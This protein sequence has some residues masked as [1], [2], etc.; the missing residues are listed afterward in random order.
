[1]NKQSL[2]LYTSKLP[3]SVQKA[4]LD[5]TGGECYLVRRRKRGK[6]SE[7]ARGACHP[8]VQGWVDKVGGS[9]VAGWLLVRNNSLIYNGLWHWTFHSVWKTPEGEL[10]DVTRD[11][12]YDGK[13]FSTFWFDSSRD[14][15]FEE[16]TS[17]NDIV[18]FENSILATAYSEKYGVNATPGLVYWAHPSLTSIKDIAEHSGIYRW[19][20]SHY[21]KNLEMMD[22]D[23]AANSPTVYFDYDLSL[24]S[25]AD[26][27]F[28]DQR[29]WEGSLS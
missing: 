20:F 23:L 18:I 1:M 14:V 21:P 6:T 11:P 17:Y 19:L 3:S 24:F 16:G 4:M 28:D 26:P 25:V 7:G 27:E 29:T 22:K 2:R 5:F 15:D 8:N 10:V 12:I 13:D 9:R